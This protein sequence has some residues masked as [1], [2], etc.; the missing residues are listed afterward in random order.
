LADVFAKII[1]GAGYEVDVFT[2]SMLALEKIGSQHS[3]YSLV[4]TGWRMRGMDGIELALHLSK[5]DPGIKIIV[6]SHY[7]PGDPIYDHFAQNGLFQNGYIFWEGFKFEHLSM[8]FDSAKLLEVVNNKIKN[9][10]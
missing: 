1:R 2:N 3:I 6:I 7:Y 5:I 9:G 10:K 4:L 8:P